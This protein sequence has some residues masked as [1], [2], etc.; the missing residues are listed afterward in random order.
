MTIGGDELARRLRQGREAARLTQ[1]EAAAALGLSRPAVVQIEKGARTV[2]GLELD[3]LARLYGTEV[4]ALLDDGD[5]LARAAFRRD[6]FVDMPDVAAALEEALRIGRDLAML[7]EAAGSERASRGAVAYDLPQPRSVHQAVTQ[8]AATA[9]A[10][11]RRMG[12]GDEPVAD[13]V[14]LLE[15]VGLRLSAIDMPE[16]VYG[17]MIVDGRAGTLVAVN[18]RDHVLR[19]TF[20]LAHEYGHA[21]FD[22]AGG[23]VVSRTDARNDLREVRANAFAAAFLM[24]EGGLHRR[25]G[26][27][28][29]GVPADLPEGTAEDRPTAPR[30]S[31]AKHVQLHDVAI[32][33]HSFGVSRLAALN[34]LRSLRLLTPKRFEALREHEAASGAAVSQLLDLPQPDHASERRRFDRRHARLALEAHLGGAIDRAELLRH[35]TEN[36]GMSSKRAEEF[37]VNLAG[38]GHAG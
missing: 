32:L 2:S 26:E 15:G 34:R 16:G 20:S 11:R 35:L 37:V 14:D 8:G 29:K 25:L 12:L 18:R 22:R 31:E 13:L 27:L 30:K 1:E 24:P 9:D 10:E 4:K 36:V 7:E 17:V 6:D 38:K 19:R 33:A 21:L 23:A 3:R 5:A 28:G